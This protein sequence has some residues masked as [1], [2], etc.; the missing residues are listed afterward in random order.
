MN[1]KN[2]ATTRFYMDQGNKIVD[3][4][5]N[6][7][8]VIYFDV[9]HD[10]FNTFMYGLWRKT[11]DK[12]PPIIDQSIF[13]LGET[14]E[15]LERTNWDSLSDEK[16]MEWLKRMDVQALLKALR[17][18]PISLDIF[19]QKNSLVKSKMTNVLQA[20]INWR[21]YGVGHKSVYKYETM[22]ETV[23]KLHIL[24]PVWEF[25]DL[26]SRNYQKECETLR[27]TLLDIENRMTL[28]NTSV[29]ELSKKTGK[30]EKVVLEVLSIMRVYVDEEGI[31]KGEDEKELV[32]SIK[33]L[34]KKSSVQ[35]K[36]QEEN[37]SEDD[38]SSNKKKKSKKKWIITIAIIILI[39]IVIIILALANGSKKKGENKQAEAKIN[40][41]KKTEITTVKET[42]NRAVINP[43]DYCDIKYTYLDASEAE[44]SYIPSDEF[45]EQE[46]GI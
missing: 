20:M 44:D 10:D 9:F 25:Y 14:I 41:K 5:S 22:D 46:F 18:R 33:R 17:F 32:D 37:D 3:I 6:I 13:G 4:L 16:K 34:S 43:F 38:K 11:D 27:K 42:D 35:K 24:E 2:E 15:T 31:I 29:Q 8:P 26:L 28:P 7:L 45:T 40:K 23:F 19:C 1:N 39:I 12:F 30:S 36:Q 21:N